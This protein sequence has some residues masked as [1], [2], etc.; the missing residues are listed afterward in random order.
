[1]SLTKEA[2]II[3]R[4]PEDSAGN[5]PWQWL[6]L[7]F[8]WMVVCYAILAAAGSVVNGLPGPLLSHI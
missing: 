3:T 7:F 1:M 6:A 4:R 5:H 2:T 8:G